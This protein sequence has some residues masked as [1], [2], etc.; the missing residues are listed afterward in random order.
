MASGA[1]RLLDEALIF[2]TFEEAIADQNFVFA[3]LQDPGT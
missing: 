1:G 3:R 2:P